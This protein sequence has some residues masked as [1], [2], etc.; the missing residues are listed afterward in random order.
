MLRDRSL[1][2]LSQQ[3]HNGLALC[4]LT[5]RSLRAD[6]AETNVTRLAR[7]AL[8]RYEL[9][10]ANHFEI[11]EQ[12]LFPA[13]D[14]ELGRSILVTELIADHR[15]LEALIA[16]LRAHPSV[17]ALERFTGRL[18]AHIRR[19]EN[20]LFEEIQKR[21]P[22]QVLDQLGKTIEEKAVRICLTP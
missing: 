16:E 4:V 14:R 5:E 22:R 15:D 11:E 10:L 9:E 19:E 1:I 18:R 8:E 3:H 7:R 17:E 2:P 21:L 6:G 13:I 20:E 12:D